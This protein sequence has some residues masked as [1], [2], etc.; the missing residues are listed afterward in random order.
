MFFEARSN[1]TPGMLLVMRNS[2]ARLDIN[3]R[4]ATNICEVVNAPAQYSWLWDNVPDVVLDS[5]ISIMFEVYR[6]AEQAVV[7]Y[8][9]GDLVLPKTGT[10]SKPATHYHRYDITPYWAASMDEHCGRYKD[11]VFYV[12]K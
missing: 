11:H 12:G 8:A 1:G 4:G 10:C 3:Y 6:I 9:T 2:L 7:E 5:E